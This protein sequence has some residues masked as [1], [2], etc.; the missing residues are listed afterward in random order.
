MRS[1]YNLDHALED[2]NQ[3]EG[4][5]QNPGEVGDQN[6]GNDISVDP[7]FDTD[8]DIDFDP[9]DIIDLFNDIIDLS[10]VV[11]TTFKSI[12]FWQDIQS[13]QI[14]PV[15]PSFPDANETGTVFLYVDETLRD[16]FDLFGSSPLFG[17]VQGTCTRTSQRTDSG[18]SAYCHFT[19]EW[20]DLDNEISYASMTAEGPVQEFAG[21]QL[22]ITGGSGDLE[23]VAGSLSL[24]PAVV[25]DFGFGLEPTADFSLDFLDGPI[26]GYLGLAVLA[27]NQAVVN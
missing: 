25:E 22:T 17:L 13:R 27:V 7:D 2:Q 4:V 6:Q 18:S 26:D 20:F 9:D 10:E 3:G 11:S 23:G 14:F 21:A 8:F 24:W 16:P 1:Y 15:N 12:Y 5:D 19:Y